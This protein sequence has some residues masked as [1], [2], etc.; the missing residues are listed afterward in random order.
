[1]EIKRHNYKWNINEVL[2][3]QREYEL[4]GM[5][6]QDI[7]K[8]HSRS[9]KAILCK[10]EREGFIESWSVIRGI[11]EFIESDND[12]CDY[13]S[14]ILDG[15]NLNNNCEISSS[16][17]SSENKSEIESEI[18]SDEETEILYENL[19]DITSETNVNESID[20]ST[21][22]NWLLLTMKAI[23]FIFQLVE[24]NFTKKMIF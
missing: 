18:E 5:S 19:L 9:G 11:E 14:L 4:L 22:K 17:T 13:K 20:Y 16:I 1:M 15:Y 7:A 8:S 24:T 10:L 6:I 21:I 12:L 2:K 23:Y 3:L